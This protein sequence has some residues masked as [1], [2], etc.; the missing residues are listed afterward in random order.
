MALQRALT[1]LQL[2]LPHSYGEIG[3]LEAMV[4]PQGLGVLKDEVVHTEEPQLR[5]IKL[6]S[7]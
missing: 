5:A 2:Y 4:G 6:A 3:W 1:Q 7:I